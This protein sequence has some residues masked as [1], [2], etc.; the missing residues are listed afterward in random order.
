LHI[1]GPSGRHY[2][3][4]LTI[5]VQ[6]V[7]TMRTTDGN[8]LAMSHSVQ[9]KNVEKKIWDIEGFAVRIMHSDGRDMRG[10][11]GGIPQYAY[12]RCARNDMT[13]EGWKNQRFKPS[14]PGLEV[15]I[16]DASGE[17]A[18]GQTKLGT[19]RDTYLEE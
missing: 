4:D 5:F 1:K 13:V 8:I 10:D 11:R 9:A 15:E 14:Y 2:C 18:P 6:L 19:V 7:L 16:L 12:E 3:A 17:T